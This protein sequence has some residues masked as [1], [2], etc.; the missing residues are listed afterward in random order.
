[1]RTFTLKKKLL[2]AFGALALLV[3]LT[4]AI[5]LLVEWQAAQRFDVFAT[6][7]TKRSE[8]VN[9][10]IAGVNA[11]A[12]GARNL[13]LVTEAAAIAAEKAAVQAAHAK[14]Q[15]SLL[16]L[17]EAVGAA[18]DDPKAPPL[19]AAIDGVESRYGPVAL[20]IVDTALAGDHRGAIAQMNQDCRPLLAEL[21]ARAD[22]YLDHN[23]ALV[24]QAVADGR[25][26][27]TDALA[28]LGG[29][30]AA[31]LGGAVLLAVLIP[32]GVMRSLG[33]DPAELSTAA[34]R[35]A[36]GD[37]GPLAG[38]AAAVPGSVLASMAAMRE[39]LARIVS[40]VRSGSD[41]IATA[42]SQIAQ[43]NQDLSSRTEQ[44][45]SSLQQ[46]AA[47]MDELGST[48]RQNADNARQAS[49]LAQGASEVAS[50]GGAVVAEV[51]DTMKGIQGS[52]QK[53]ADII[54]T[55]DGIA[56]QTNILALNAAVEAARAG[57]QGRG[58][59]V[60]ASEV[61]SLAQR[62]AEAAKE[63]KTL[64]TDSVARVESGTAL[65]DRAGQTMSEIVGAIG[66]VSDIVGEISVASAEQSDGVGQVGQ[67]V[68][69][70]D[71]VTQQNAALVEESAA[72]ADSLRLQARQ[73][74][75][76][77]AVFKLKD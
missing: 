17:R 4:A 6:G 42:S 68:N 33:A 28:L 61:R 51:V 24:K 70:M 74:V 66:R 29:T 55:I 71:Q 67:A 56:F 54:G 75:D 11:R 76:A 62:S 16:A 26:A 35:I 69:Q 45:A 60:V 48:V 30:L 14:V 65:V 12:I 20:K 21:L 50:R 58:F 18:A 63:I 10:V 23:E 38:A 7:V 77:V 25:R 47:S 27:S 40:Q 37:L 46:T 32:R 41:S 9:D 52:S 73:L 15:Q 72:A 59:A 1:M 53:I 19:M 8:L 49:Q 57:E 44:Q 64:I 3:S 22:A 13:V 39:N 2:S 31:G 34:E 36:G 43:G 5:G